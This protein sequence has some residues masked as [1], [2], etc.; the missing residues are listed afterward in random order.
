[1]N[2]NMRN[3]KT[4]YKGIFGFLIA[5]AL[6]LFATQT[7]VC[8]TET[9]DIVTYTPPAGWAK[10][11]KNGAVIY[12]DIDKTTNGF[13][14][15]TVYASTQSSGD[16][17]K[18]F[19]NTWNDQVVKPF[20]AAPNPKTETQTDPQGWKGTVGA[21]QIKTE[22]GLEGYAVLTV[23]SGFGKTASILAI[24]NNQSYLAKVDT[25]VAGVKLDKTKA[26]AVTQTP[27]PVQN[28]PSNLS[29]KD[30]FPDKPNRGPQEPLA[31]PLKNSITMNDLA[32]N[33]S[34]G[35]ANVITYVNS[36]SGNYGGTDTTFFSDFY[37]IKADGTFESRFQGRTANHTVRETSTGT[38]TLSGGYIYVKYTGGESRGTYKYQFIA[39]M[40]LPN[41][42]AVLTLIHV[43]E[44]DAGYSPDA[45]IQV[46]G[47]AHAYITCGPG[48]E[49]IRK[50]AK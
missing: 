35:G 5:Q 39:Y 19:A 21:A 29:T 46:C 6:C 30:P 14:I 9:L 13:C 34:E 26:L 48:I 27:Q 43:G 44:N 3:N 32:G 20:K 40:V 36:G 10:T 37:A 24:L 8:Q 4:I 41:G 7:A 25:L 18:D 47:H 16:P 2:K 17:Q 11:Y 50:P 28:V 33:W 15:L 12:S 45:L 42:G 1:M 49:W 22:G 31:G 23:F 38:I